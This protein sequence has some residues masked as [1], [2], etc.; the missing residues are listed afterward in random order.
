MQDHWHF[1]Y[2]AEGAGAKCRA[3]LVW[4]FACALHLRAGVSKATNGHIYKSGVFRESLH[5]IL[6][7]SVALQV[8]F[9]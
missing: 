8:G 9:C 2:Q 6:N 4:L 3:Q 1:L 5:F 7:H